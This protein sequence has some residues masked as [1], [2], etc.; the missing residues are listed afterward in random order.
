MAFSSICR[1]DPTF[2][3]RA[4]PLVKA[5]VR[6]AREL[7]VASRF[8]VYP[9]IRQSVASGS[10]PVTFTSSPE[11]RVFL[12]RNRTSIDLYT[13]VANCLFRARE[14]VVGSESSSKA[15]SP[16]V[17]EDL[18]GAARCLAEVKKTFSAMFDDMTPM[19]FFSQLVPFYSPVVVEGVPHR[20][21]DARDQPGVFCTDLLLGVADPRYIEEQVI[22]NLHYLI[23]EHQDLVRRALPPAS[24]I[25]NWLWERALCVAPEKISRGEVAK[26]LRDLELVSFAEKIVAVANAHA[27]LGK[28]HMALVLKFMNS[29]LEQCK[30]APFYQMF[31]GL[32][33]RSLAHLE[34]LTGMRLNS[35]QLQELRDALA[36]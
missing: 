19:F 34:T 5:L 16:S 33:D 15:S 25:L 18:D 24:G 3:G 13:Q 10:S 2:S 23:P 20:P 6:Q 36:R 9:Y 21:A 7:G 27:E 22:P 32:M 31:R 26:K 8:I 29:P 17:I 11:E 1:F 30:E 14:S 4:D 28:V 35:P 12:V